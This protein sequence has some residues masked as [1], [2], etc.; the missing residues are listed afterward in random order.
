[1]CGRFSRSRPIK[2]YAEYFVAESTEADSPSYNVCPT[3]DVL[4]VV[5]EPDESRHLTWLHWGL[6][7][8][9]S[10]GPDSRYSMINA[11]AE[12]LSAKPAY[13]TA[14]RE[15]RCL[16]VA[17]GFY[18]WR[19]TPDGKQPYFVHLRSGEPM[20]FAGLWDYWEAKD[21]SQHINSATIITT[22]ANSLVETI[23]ERM[24]AMILPK[25][26][27][28]WLDPGIRTV[29]KIE[30]LLMPIDSGLM[31]I[32]P[33]STKVNSPANQGAELIEPL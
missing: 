16:I 2:E 13:R 11:R 32:W 19:K 24:P 5:A 31:E 12:T 20:A 7:P 1:M 21:G 26:I 33:V 14:F 28:A 10:Q 17:D 15:H 22:T 8:S 29:S 25:D 27:T 3:D 23:H 6:V 18:E 4:A 9:W 30:E